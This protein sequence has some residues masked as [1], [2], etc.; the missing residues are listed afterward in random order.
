MLLCCKFVSQRIEI[1]CHRFSDVEFEAPVDTVVDK[2]L[3]LKFSAEICA[4]D[5]DLGVNS[6]TSRD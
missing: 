6:T 1:R 4:E 2:H 5:T 3:D